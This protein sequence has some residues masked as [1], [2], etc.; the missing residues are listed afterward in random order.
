MAELL[1]T[2]EQTFMITGRGLIFVPGIKKFVATGTEVKIIKP[3]KTEIFSVITGVEHRA[4]NGA[5]AV[6]LRGGFAKADIPIGT[7]VWT[8]D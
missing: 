8:L 2:V 7:E 5:H 1:F 3:D 6:L 4:V